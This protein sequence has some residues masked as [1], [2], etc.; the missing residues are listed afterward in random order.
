[1]PEIVPGVRRE[2]VPFEKERGGAPLVVVEVLRMRTRMLLLLSLI[3]GL[4]PPANPTA[5]A[6][7]AVTTAVAEAAGSAVRARCARPTTSAA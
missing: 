7:S 2:H 5:P 3:G 6:M 4:L 1:M